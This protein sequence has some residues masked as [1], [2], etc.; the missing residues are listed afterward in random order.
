MSSNG[1]CDDHIQCEFSQR[2][3]A[4]EL[5][6]SLPSHS[7]VPAVDLYES[8]E[9]INQGVLYLYYIHVII[10]YLIYIYR[11]FINFPTLYFK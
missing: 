6:V 8:R 10:P 3:E 7:S 11:I 5:C 1:D 4:L 2:V 9:R